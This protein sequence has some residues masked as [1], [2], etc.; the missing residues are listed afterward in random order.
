MGLGCPKNMPP[1]WELA[2]C[3]FN[4]GFVLEMEI[5]AGCTADWAFKSNGDTSATD[6][7]PKSDCAIVGSNGWFTESGRST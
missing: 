6:F 4:T 2:N 3:V 1:D 5:M 7:M